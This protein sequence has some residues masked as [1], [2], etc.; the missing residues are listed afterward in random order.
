MRVWHIHFLFTP[1]IKSRT[2]ALAAALVQ[3]SLISLHRTDIIACV[4]GKIAAVE[5]LLFGNTRTPRIFSSPLSPVPLP[6]RFHWIFEH[7]FQIP[8]TKIFHVKLIC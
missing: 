4:F 6:P 7:L 2:G 5:T 8:E 3:T 1:A